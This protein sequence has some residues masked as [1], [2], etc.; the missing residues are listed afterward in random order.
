MERNRQLVAVA[1]ERQPA[2][3]AQ[4][5]AETFRG[6]LGDRTGV[7]C[8]IHGRAFYCLGFICQGKYLGRSLCASKNFRRIASRPA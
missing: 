7:R 5:H 4:Q 1:Q 6:T 8:I 2:D 3:Q